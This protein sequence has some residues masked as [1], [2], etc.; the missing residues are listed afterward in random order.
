MKSDLPRLMQE[1]NMDALVVFGVDGLGPANTAFTYFTGDAH[2]SSG[3]VMIKRD[4]DAITQ[5]LVHRSMEREEAAKTGMA[6]VN[7]ESYRFPEIVAAMGGDRRKAHVEHMRRIF[8]DLGIG[9]R[10]GFYGADN[11]G[12][13]FTLLNDLIRAEVCEVMVEHENDVIAAARQTKDTREAALI[14]QSVHLTEAV[15][16]NTRDFLRG[17]RVANGTLLRADGAPLTIGDAKAFIRRSALDLGLR[18]TDCIFSTGRDSAI[19]HSVG[20]PS[21]IIQQGKTIVFDIYPPGPGGYYADITR[22][23]CLG[24]APDHVQAAYE[25]VMK[26]HAA[27]E[28]AFAAGVLTHDV[29][30]LACD[31]FE[32]AGHNTNRTNYGSDSGYYH[33]LGHG[34]G[35]DVHEAP[36]MALRGT[37]PDE[38]FQTGAIICNEPG[39]YYPDDPRGGWGVRVEDDY[40][41]NPNGVFERLSEFDRALVIA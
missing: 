12:K 11:V 28:G 27:A 14:R 16:G 30:A 39:L 34:F 36:Y 23:W 31:I 10:V 37:R 19:G 7:Y 2:V 38:Y 15:I 29:H 24:Y 25:T 26:V 17:H 4:G 33:G 6:L 18:Y 13:S 5:H 32:A 40:W 9:G 3:F 41:C 21:D 35:L 20:T 8:A 22:T 1:R